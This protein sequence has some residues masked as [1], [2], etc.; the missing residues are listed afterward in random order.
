MLKRL[1]K[2]ISELIQVHREHLEIWRSS[3]KEL[4]RL[5]AGYK[6]HRDQRELFIKMDISKTELGIMFPNTKEK[7][8][9][10][11]EIKI[12]DLDSR[13]RDKL[14]IMETQ[15]NTVLRLA[16][17]CAQ[18]A[19]GVEFSEMMGI[20]NIQL[21]TGF[22][23]EFCFDLEQTYLNTIN[24]ML[25]FLSINSTADKFFDISHFENVLS[26]YYLL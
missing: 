3:E 22:L 4:E 9:S 12:S 16:A 20:K 8:I 17:E 21:E 10:K 23:V 11:L 6:N 19:E 7:L 26:D 13:L 5:E 1:E 2:G 24:H 25:H 15:K 14:E 18:A